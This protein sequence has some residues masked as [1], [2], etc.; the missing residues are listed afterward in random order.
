M[1]GASRWIIQNLDAA[2]KDHHRGFVINIKAVVVGETVIAVTNAKDP[3][4]A[5]WD[6][7]MTVLA[8]HLNRRAGQPGR[9]VVFAGGG[10]PSSAMR[11]KLRQ[12]VEKR[13]L[14]TAVV[15]DS[16][17]VRSIIGVFALFVDGTKPFN[18][19]DWK[20]SLTYVGFPMENVSELVTAARALD[21]EVG[22]SSALVAL[23][24]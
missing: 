8:D 21:A 19:R 14:L 5:G 12:V 6:A 17:V 4:V 23:L 3:E 7:Y 11:L 1:T 2:A 24:K 22:G 15:T 20:D 10:T 9:L 16:T 18:P 13:K